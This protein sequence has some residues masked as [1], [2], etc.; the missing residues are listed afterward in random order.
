M[1]SYG[2]FEQFNT[3]FDA[4]IARILCKKGIDINNSNRKEED[5]QDISFIIQNYISEN[6]RLI[7]QIYKKNQNYYDV[8]TCNF[9]KNFY[10]I[11]GQCIQISKLYCCL[12]KETCKN[13]VL[14]ADKK[15]I[16][17]FVLAKL[18]GKSIRTYSEIVTLISN[19]FSYGAAS[20]TR[21]L[22]EL[23]IVT[24]FILKCDSDVA[25][26]Y[27]NASKKPL[28]EQDYNNYSWA[29]SSSLFEQD[30]KI[31]L[32]KLQKKCE[33]D[34]PIHY[35]M[36]AFHCKFAHATPQTISFDIDADTDDILFGP[37][38][39]GVDAPAINA[40]LLV[41]SVLLD[42]FS[43]LDED[44]I[45]IKALFCAEWVSYLC[46]EY[47]KV[48]KGLQSISDKSNTNK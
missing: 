20:L 34:N 47:K 45:S 8:E 43:Y 7:K 17:G 9:F 27:Y 10:E 44:K 35:K 2:I 11:W 40:A 12:L 23:M 3:D 37:T 6:N 33:L 21:T 22:F 31:T 25:L 42:F 14:I 24:R 5:F 48:A 46:V 29:K 38:M 26:K 41:R 1:K 4:H 13:T 28:D 39:Q 36:Y 18:M 15:D 16:K 19:G 30:E 32:S